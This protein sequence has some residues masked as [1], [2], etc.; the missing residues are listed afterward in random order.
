VDKATNNVLYAVYLDQQIIRILEQDTKQKAWIE[1][2]KSKLP[3]SCFLWIENPNKSIGWHLPYREGTGGI[4]PQTKLYRSA[5]P[6]NLGALRAIAAA[7]NKTELKAPAEIK[8]KIKK[9]LKKYDIIES[10]KGA[11]RMD[12]ELREAII[13]NQFIEMSLDKE[14]RII[15]NVAI[16]RS[17][18]SNKYLRG[19]KGTI[20][21]EQALRDTARLINGKKFYFNHSSESE[22]K[23]NRGVRRVQ[24]LA[25][26]YEN[27]RLDDNHVVRGD[28]HYRETHA[29]ELEDLVDNMADK[30]G[31]SIHAFGP[32]SIDR[33]KNMGVTESMSKVAS[34]DLV[35]ETG[36]T[37]NLFESKQGE[38]EEED[39]MEY[40][41]IELKELRKERPDLVEAVQKEVKESMQNDDELKTLK[42]T[43]DTLAKENTDL[44][45]K[46]DDGEVLEAARE[47][48]TKI[49]ELIEA[50]KLKDKKDVVTPRFMES[51]RGAKDEA[52]M[53]ALIEDRV[54]L[55]ESSKTGVKGMGDEHT[56][57]NEQT[58]EVLES[59]K[60]EYEVAIAE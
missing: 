29:K 22:D 59:K 4:D 11:D 15:S 47:R 57:E 14:K 5:G 21:S 32:M 58:K 25:G 53:K 54:K 30:I 17:T 50:S 42:E 33:D 48:E 52:D 60:K 19:T 41:K 45:K 28:I 18:S 9:M 3:R 12:T 16:L 55:I 43:N 51:L 20:F 34:A 27:G 24:D 44:K 36:S 26:Y 35:T 7:M 10:K 8:S 37:I 6:V 23:D 31:L 1:V 2:D 49:L 40:G 46:V 13:D 38:G 39:E 56:E